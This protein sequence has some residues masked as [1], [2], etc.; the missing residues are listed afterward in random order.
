MPHLLRGDNAG[1][2]G[3]VDGRAGGDPQ[4]RTGGRPMRFAIHFD[5]RNDVFQGDRRQEEIARTLEATAHKIRCGETEGRVNDS[6]GNSIGFFSE[7]Q[8]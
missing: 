7:V 8:G 3:E 4:N 6:N 1:D 2:V 5:L